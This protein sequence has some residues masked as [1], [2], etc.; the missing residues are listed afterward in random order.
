M[1]ATAAT[2]PVIRRALGR[3]EAAIYLGISPS[4]FDEMRLDG[5]IRPPRVLDGRKL[6]DVFDLDLAFEALPVDNKG[7]KS[8]DNR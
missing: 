3:E 5:R 4:K 7:G 6:W 8:W 2:R 1:K